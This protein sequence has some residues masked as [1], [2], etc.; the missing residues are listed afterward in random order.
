MKS[1]AVLLSLA[2]FLCVGCGEVDLHHGLDEV[3]AS[4]I[5]VLLSQN[6]IDAKKVKEVQGQEVSWKLTVPASDGA[7]ARQILVQN[8]LPHK[9]ELGLS[10]VYK[11]KG[12]IPTPDEQKARFLLALKGEIINSLIKVPGVADADI[13]LNI[14]EEDKFS[15]LD[16]QQKQPTA[17]VIV[18]GRPGSD[19]S[20][21]TEEK[22]QHFVA[23]SVPNLHPGN[24]AVIMTQVPGQEG[25]SSGGASSWGSGDSQ[26]GVM[27]QA[28]PA[29]VA[30]ESADLKEIAGLKMDPQSSRL[31]RLYA[32]MGLAV[33]MLM[34]I[35]LIVNVIRLNRLRQNQEELNMK[36]LPAGTEAV[37]AAKGVGAKGA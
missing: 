11:D 19:Y 37:P 8:N 33:V 18:R 10:G 1:R 30:A 9:R 2:F 4:E 26:D 5:L 20:T 29:Q 35:A 32:L 25:A 17:S 34:S 22:I 12:L 23:N 27:P 24:V 14:P 15:L 6:G 36:A 31:F 21:L 28:R 13:V 7:A 3:E 16:E